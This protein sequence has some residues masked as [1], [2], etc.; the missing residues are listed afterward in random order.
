MSFSEKNALILKKNQY[1]PLNAQ[2]NIW[3]PKS[4]LTLLLPSTVHGRV[5]DIWRAYVA[6]KILQ[7]IKGTIVVSSPF[8]K[9]IRNSHNYLSD[10]NSEI[11]LY[12]KVR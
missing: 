9:Q 8:I 7:Q 3:F 10:F 4:Y 1:T 12:E 2:S 5:S 11:P 6:E